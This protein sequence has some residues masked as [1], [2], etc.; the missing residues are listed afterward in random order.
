MEIFLHGALLNLG[1]LLGPGAQNIFVF[2]QGIV[3]RKALLVGGTSSLCDMVLLG[4]GVFGIGAIISASPGLETVLLVGGILFLVYHGYKNFK[5]NIHVDCKNTDSF[6]LTNRRLFTQ[7]LSFSLLNPSV[8]LDTVAIVGVAGG[9]YQTP[10][11]ALF[12]L[13]ATTTS[14]LW[15]FSLCFL[16]RVVGASSLGRNID[17]INKLAGIGMFINALVLST[18]WY[19]NL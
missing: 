11:N 7:T 1:L 8:Y 3:S 15:F 16:G 9:L 17:F 14:T 2:Q 18:L 19:L 6:N 13:G 12:F 10:N 5:L 4:L